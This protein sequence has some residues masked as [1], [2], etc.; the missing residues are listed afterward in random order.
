V[1]AIPTAICAYLIHGARLLWLDR[2][3][4]RTSVKQEVAAP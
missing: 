4:A 1:W 3:I 2:T